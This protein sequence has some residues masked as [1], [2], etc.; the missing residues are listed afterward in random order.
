MTARTL[1]AAALLLALPMVQTPARAG[2]DAPIPAGFYRLQSA[3]TLAGRA[4][5]W[6]Y[7]AY[8]PATGILLIGRRGAGLW[9]FDT[10]AH[11]LVRKL[12][13]TDGAG[14]ALAIPALNRGFTTNEDG[15]TTVFKLSTL[16]T[17]RRVKFAE[18]ADSGTYDPATGQI[19]FMSG[20]SQKITLI[21]ARSLKITGTITMASKKLEASATDG[22]GHLF[23]AERDRN[24]LAAIDLQTRSVTQEWPTT[25]CI[26]PTGLAMD[27]AHRRVFLGCRGAHPVLAVMDADD[28]HV[29]ATPD[30][31]HGNDGVVYDAARHRILTTNGIEANI[32]IYHQDDADHYRIEQAITTRPSARTIAFDALRQ[33]IF[34][35][36]AEGV[37]AGDRPV[38]TGPSAFY[39]NAYYDNS[40]AV[41]T[42][43][44]TP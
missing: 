2:E 3:V 12:A 44:P 7:L 25:G 36:T 4:P 11:R 16:A 17:I 43:A 10:R 30:L 18:D 41:L 9:A 27:V 6:D 14:A 34:T 35:V 15:S 31:G 20:D 32:V 37:V 26:Q 5:D 39:P 1:L 19:A 42:Y 21:D 38:N 8:L 24:M 28:G 33:R 29:I 13:D 23:V 22:A 40:F